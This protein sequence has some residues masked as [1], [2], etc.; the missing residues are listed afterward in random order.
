MEIV[1]GLHRIET[2]LGNRKLYQ[3]L[4]VGD[5]IILIDTG[6]TNTLSSHVF[7]Y[8]ESIG[9]SPSDIDMAIISHAD[10]DHFGGNEELRN[11]A[12]HAWIAC[13][14]NDTEWI[15]DPEAIMKGR[16]DQFALSHS[17]S[18]PDEVKE[19]LRGMMGEAVPVD[20][21]FTGGETILMSK[22]RPLRVL[23]LPGHTR[24][25]I[26]V[27]DPT[28]KSAVLTDAILWKGLPDVDGNIVLPPTYCHADTYKT[29]IQMVKHLDIDTLCLSHFDL[30]K[31]KPAIEVFIAETQRFVDRVDKAILDCLSGDKPG[32]SLKDLV[33]FTD[34]VLGPFGDARP[35]LAY[36]LS[37]HMTELVQ[38]GRVEE[39]KDQGFTRWRLR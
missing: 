35:E 16:Y 39:I 24:G 26:G 33:A 32:R 29:T 15:S 11:T 20:L 31:G 21:Q 17:I 10:A 36:P 3:H 13:H 37:G 22:R 1:P 18:Y 19:F 30:L 9:R 38:Q 12:P 5:R 25:H 23:F 27:Y 28:E 2:L 8:L 4:Y 6:I 34:S 14:A 7:P